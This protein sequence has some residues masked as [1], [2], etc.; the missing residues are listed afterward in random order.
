MFCVLVYR[1]CVDDGLLCNGLL[2][3]NSV[4]VFCSRLYCRLFDCLLCLFVAASWLLV[5]ECCL[6]FWICGCLF[7]RL[8]VVA[9]GFGDCLT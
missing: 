9:V 5:C 7:Y 1:G 8:V 4:V 6:L 2:L 3:L